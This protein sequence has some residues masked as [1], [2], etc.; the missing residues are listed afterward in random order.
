MKAAVQRTEVE[1]MQGGLAHP[2]GGDS[3]RD[4]ASGS[5]GDALIESGRFARPWQGVSGEAAA[6]QRTETEEKQAQPAAR[7]GCGKCA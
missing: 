1:E 6:V 7:R 4:K 3:W 5:T 2:P